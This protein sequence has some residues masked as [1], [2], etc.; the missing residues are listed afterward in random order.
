MIMRTYIC[1]QCK[2]LHYVP[3]DAIKCCN[4][5]HGSMIQILCSKDS[6]VVGDTIVFTRDN[7]CSS[8]PSENNDW[9]YKKEGKDEAGNYCF[10]PYY[11]VSGI[12]STN[13]TYQIVTKIH[14]GIKKFCLSNKSYCGIARVLDPPENTIME[15]A[16]RLIKSSMP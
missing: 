4:F 10:K 1:K 3:K 9:I 15:M 12:N 11:L 6:L 13:D 14:G 16:E 2:K 5:Y 8:I 7:M